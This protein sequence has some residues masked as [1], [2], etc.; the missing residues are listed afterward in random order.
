[1]YNLQQQPGWVSAKGH[2][3]SKYAEHRGAGEHPAHLSY[4]GHLAIIVCIHGVTNQHCSYYCTRHALRVCREDGEDT[5]RR[6]KQ[7]ACQ[8]RLLDWFEENKIIWVTVLAALA[9]IQLMVTIIA[10]YI[11]QKVK[12]IS[13][14]RYIFHFHLVS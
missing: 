13:K 10:A 8:D 9:A 5:T 4:P 3:A 12:K 14:M 6:M 7:E 1:M 2:T 11:I